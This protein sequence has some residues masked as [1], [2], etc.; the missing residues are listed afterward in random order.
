[1]HPCQ[2]RTPKNEIKRRIEKLQ[3]QLSDMDIDA[4]LII[5]NSDLFYFAGTTQQSHLYVPAEGEPILLARKN[6]SRAKSESA[7]ERIFPMNTSRQIP[8]LLQEYGYP[9]PDTLGLECD[10]LPVNLYLSYQKLFHKSRIT[11]VS[12][13]IRKIRAVKSD[14]EIHLISLAA[15][16]ADQVAACMP[17]FLCEGITEIEL[18]GKIEAYARKLGHQGIIRMRLFGSELFYGHLMSGPSAAIPSY[19]SSPTGGPGSSPATA[20]GPGF[21]AIKKKEPV[22]L[23]YVFALSGYLADHT[24]IYSLGTLPHKMRNAH[25]AMLDVQS[26]IKDRARPGMPAG[27][28]YQ[29]ARERVATLGY[30]ENFMGT[31]TQR[32]RFVGHGLGIELDEYPFLAS[33]QEILLEEGMV[34]ALEPK[35]VF[36]GEGVVGIENTHIVTAKGLKQ[37]TLFPDEIAVI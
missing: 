31:G 20:Q 1:M 29:M 18:A 9:I 13:I 11:D 3:K 8:S 6:F 34:L 36:P 22:L 19:L 23:D 24:R 17:E 32:I 28:I 12:P 25:D 2:N 21:R 4:A 16:C 33:D 10:V 15:R 35:L 27:E 37:L 14:Y 5:Q 7:M 26:M 30:E